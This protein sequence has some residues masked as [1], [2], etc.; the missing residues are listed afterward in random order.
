MA[1][2]SATYS[3][4]VSTNHRDS[5]RMTSAVGDRMTTEETP[6]QSSFLEVRIYYHEFSINQ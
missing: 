1:Q 6:I 5:V 4:L 3:V 2:E